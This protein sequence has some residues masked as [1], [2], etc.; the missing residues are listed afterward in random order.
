MKTIIRILFPSF[1][2]KNIFYQCVAWISLVIRTIILPIVLPAAFEPIASWALR[3]F[4]ISGI[5][6]EIL[7]R[8]VLALFD[9]VI[10]SQVLYRTTFF[11][12]GNFYEANSEPVVGSVC[13]LV[14]FLIQNVSIVC[15]IRYFNWLCIG[16]VIGGYFIFN[17]TYY[18]VS[19]FEGTISKKWKWRLALHVILF[20]IAAAVIILLK[21]FIF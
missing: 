20:A 7:L 1:S 12:V 21:V 3:S 16:L 13:Y 11:T 10:L 9:G 17:T 5:L 19:Y 15:L 6:Y 14:L 2:R 18:I 8:I 4:N